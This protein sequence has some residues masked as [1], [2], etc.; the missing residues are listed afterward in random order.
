MPDRAPVSDVGG[1]QE[2][3]PWPADVAEI[4]EGKAYRRP[5]TFADGTT[6][7]VDVDVTGVNDILADDGTPTDG[8]AVTYQ[9]DDPTLGGGA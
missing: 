3:G 5:V 2:D 8:Y 4:V 6:G 1:T 7:E 9:F